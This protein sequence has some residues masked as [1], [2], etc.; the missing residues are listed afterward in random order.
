MLQIPSIFFPWL[1]IG[2]YEPL[3]TWTT[4]SKNKVIIFGSQGGTRTHR[5]SILNAVCIPFHHSAKPHILKQNLK[6]QYMGNCDFTMLGVEPRIWS[7]HTYQCSYF[8]NLFY[9]LNDMPSQTESI[10][11]T[12]PPKCQVIFPK[13]RKN[14]KI[15]KCILIF[16]SDY[17][18]ISFK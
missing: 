4:Y 10:R 6:K 2:A 17:N 1:I 9:Y 18:S 7:D 13:F 3:H 16:P 11:A 8:H 12:I 15:I 14:A 5:T